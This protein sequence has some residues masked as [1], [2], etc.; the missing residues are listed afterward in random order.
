MK[1]KKWFF[2]IL[3]S[4]TILYGIVL[5]INI[6]IDPY[7]VFRSP[8]FYLDK[9]FN[10]R[11]LKIEWLKENK[12]YVNSYIFGSSRVGSTFPDTIEQYIPESKF[13]NMS[14]IYGNIVDTNKMI[15]YLVTNNFP[16]KNIYF[17]IDMNAMSSKIPEDAYYEKRHNPDVEHT[18]KLLFYMQHLIIFPWGKMKRK[19]ENHFSD[20]K[21]GFYDLENTG[22]MFRLK[23]DKKIAEDHELYIKNE[24]SFHRRNDR[25]I[26]I[27]PED[28]ALV[29]KD[30]KHLV[31]LCNENNI[32]LI[33][34]TTPL[35]HQTMDKFDIDSSLTFIK[36]ITKIHDIWYF[37]GYNSVTLDNHNFYEES[38]YLYHIPKL[39]A[40]RIFDDK[41]VNIP[42]D[43]GVLLTKKNYQKYEIKLKENMLLHDKEKKESYRL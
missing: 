4:A 34:Y 7:G 43:F 8:V 17:Q 16:V 2:N 1:A 12:K 14:V 27:E 41:T 22:V 15:T 9:G 40:A 30:L 33:L 10:E 37:S 24:L 29:M 39:I 32:N 35:N 5:A 42:A 25:V 38:H 28:Y 36:D 18:S 13:Y 19:I 11:Y 21:S 6:I 20:N 31:R 23:L 26:K 3:I